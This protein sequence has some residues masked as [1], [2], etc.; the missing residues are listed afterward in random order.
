MRSYERHYHCHPVCYDGLNKQFYLPHLPK[1]EVAVW[2]LP[3]CYPVTG[4]P[5]EP[6]KL[7]ERFILWLETGKAWTHFAGSAHK[8]TVFIYNLSVMQ[9]AYEYDAVIVGSG[10]NGLAA[11]IILARAGWKTLV[12]ESHSTPG[13]G[14]RTGEVTLPGFSHDICSSV[15]PLAASSRLFTRLPLEKFGLKWI[16]PPIAVGHP[17]DDGSAILAEQDLAVTAEQLGQ[18]QRAYIHLFEKISESYTQLLE[19]LHGPLPL[20]PRHPILTGLFGLKAV[21]TAAGLNRR[22]FKEEKARALFAGYAAHSILPLE[23]PGTA[24]AGLLIG[25]SVHAIGWPIAAGGSQAIANSLVG[26]LE[27]L[28]GTVQTN[29]EVTKLDELPKCRAVLLDI[30]ARA[31]IRLSGEK[32]PSRY[33]TRLNK[34]RYGS[35]IFKI[36]YALDGPVP[37]KNPGLLNTITVHVGGTSAEICASEAAAHRGIHTERPFVLVA[38]ASLFDPNRAPAGKHTLWAYCHVPSGSTIDMTGPL[39]AQI[40]RFAPGFRERILARK[41]TNSQELEAYNPNYVGGDISS[42]E[43]NLYQQF[44]RPVASL[45]PYRTPLKGVYLC[46]SSTPPG[47]GVH[48]MCGYQAAKR[49][50]KDFGG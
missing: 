43:Q 46:S 44:A 31:L 32:L 23:T 14:M 50:L 10:P 35:G 33:R 30:S 21:Q 29:W 40:E 2:E 1:K 47:G 13:G 15:H 27:S 41:T 9:S 7:G 25:G 34:F 48:G 4:N 36:D 3:W 12:I 28:G 19:D 6:K 24:A 38:Q 45:S 16:F 8:V 42:G 5:K 49:V 11:A 22:V 26:Y 37:W 17:L 18:D 39:E 20:P